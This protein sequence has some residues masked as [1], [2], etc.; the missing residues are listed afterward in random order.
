MLDEWEERETRQDFG[1]EKVSVD[2]DELGLG[3]GRLKIKVSEVD[4]SKEGVRRD[5]RVK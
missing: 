2:F 4:G 3:E 5:N 1:G